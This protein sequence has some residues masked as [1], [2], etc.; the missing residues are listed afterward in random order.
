[1]PII[2]RSHPKTNSDPTKE[3]REQQMNSML[4]MVGASSK[5]AEPKDAEM[6]NANYGPKRGGREG[7]APRHET[8]P[9]WRYARESQQRVTENKVV[10]HIFDL[11]HGQHQHPKRSQDQQ[12]AHVWVH[13]RSAN[14]DREAGRRTTHR[15]YA[16]EERRRSMHRSRAAHEAPQNVHGQSFML[17]YP[18]YPAE[19]QAGLQPY[20]PYFADNSQGV[21]PPPAPPLDLDRLLAQYP[22]SIPGFMQA[23]QKPIH[24][25]AQTIH[26]GGQQ[27]Q[28]SGPDS[29]MQYPRV[30]NINI[31]GASGPTIN[32]DGGRGAAP[33][34]EPSAA[35][36]NGQEWPRGARHDK[37]AHAGVTVA[38]YLRE[39]AP[40]GQ[41][42]LGSSPAR[43]SLP[44]PPAFAHR[45]P[46]V[47]ASNIAPPTNMLAES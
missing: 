1:M 19:G 8:A 41:A 35:L 10:K 36:P 5:G 27:P 16:A 38:S 45:D 25:Q 11:Q 39:P 29:Q 6:I 34:N 26:N 3:D 23:E 40:D 20:G 32:Q 43:I 46:R 9:D 21:Q 2:D 47:A 24:L 33:L 14:V 37:A 4:N 42:F 22:S 30:D 7:Q 31:Q 44:Q 28:Y 15:H 17:P 18:G 12:E 13:S